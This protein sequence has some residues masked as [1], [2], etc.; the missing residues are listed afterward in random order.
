MDGAKIFELTMAHAPKS[1]KRLLKYS[2]FSQKDIDFLMVHQA[3]KQIVNSVAKLSGFTPEKAPSSSFEKFGNQSLVSIPISINHNFYNKF[4]NGRILCCSF[5]NGFA[6]ASAIF[7]FKDIY[8]SGISDYKNNSETKSYKEQ[9]E[10][11]IKKIKG[12]N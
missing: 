9:K 4:S 3:N 11:W 6:W 1:I 12:E 8:L 5:G 10:Y 7:E 2:S